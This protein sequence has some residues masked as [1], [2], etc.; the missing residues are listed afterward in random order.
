MLSNVIYH[1][2]HSVYSRICDGKRKIILQIV[3][4]QSDKIRDPTTVLSEEDLLQLNRL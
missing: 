1:Y 4:I 2:L 3:K